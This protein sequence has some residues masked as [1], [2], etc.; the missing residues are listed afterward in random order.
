MRIYKTRGVS[1]EQGAHPCVTV[2]HTALAHSALDHII[3]KETRHPVCK[4][5]DVQKE[6]LDMTERDGWVSDADLQ[7][8]SS[9]ASQVYGSNASS[10]TG[11]S[12][13]FAKRQAK[14]IFEENAAMAA[15]SV[16]HLAQHGQNENVRLK[17]AEMILNR[18]LGVV[19]KAD[20]GAT[21]RLDELFEKLSENDEDDFS[22]ASPGSDAPSN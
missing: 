16:V 14:T 10:T 9:L 12:A 19:A 20:D 7:A 11:I 1:S 18:A 15:K 6:V 5:A 21:D 22:D 4:C 3:Y 17:A 8:A 2:T 13:A